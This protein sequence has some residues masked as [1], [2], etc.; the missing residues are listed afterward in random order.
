MTTVHRS[1][2]IAAPADRVWA[3]VRDFAGLDRWVPALPAP[4]ELVGDPEKPG[5]ERMFRNDGEIFVVERLVTLDDEARITSYS[6][7][8]S[9]A[10]LTDHLGTI[11]VTEQEDGTLVEWQATFDTDEQFAEQFTMMMGAGTFEPGLQRLAELC[12]NEQGEVA[13]QG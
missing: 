6:I 1:R 13:R 7:V 9:P 11:T 2:L 5:A 8:T 12:E 4:L 10:P 3:L